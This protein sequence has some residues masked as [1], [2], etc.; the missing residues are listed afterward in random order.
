MPRDVRIQELGDGVEVAA[1]GGGEA[2]AGQLGVVVRHT[3]NVTERS[4]GV[5]PAVRCQTVKVEVLYFEGCPGFADLMPRLR[6]LVADDA[7][8]ELLQVQSAEQADRA[9]FLGSPT[10][11]VDD[12]DVEPG[13][14]ERADFGMKCRLYRTDDGVTNAPPLDWIKQ[15]LER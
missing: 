3:P 6:K 5:S 13:A 2:P 10:V 9:R 14:T 7:A 4:L 15:A 8:I 12:V 11:R 1:Q